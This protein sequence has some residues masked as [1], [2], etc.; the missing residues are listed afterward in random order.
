M[1]AAVALALAP[2]H[3]ALAGTAAAP[4]VQDA[5]G[6]ANALAVQNAK[7]ATSPASVA[8]YDIL[9]VWFSGSGNVNLRLAAAPAPVGL[10][11]VAFNAPGCTVPDSGPSP[12]AAV[13]D[14]HPVSGVGLAL[15]L[16]SSIGQAYYV[17]NVSGN[18]WGVTYVPYSLTGN[19]ITFKIPQSGH[20]VPGAA[21]TRPYAM[22]A[23]ATEA[24]VD[25]TPRGSNAVL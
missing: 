25:I 17:C 12:T 6:D 9:S 21:I 8:A 2:A 14:D 1:A 22:S 5:A 16:K 24:L 18:D 7:L 23:V 4:E 13:L 19:T 11:V 20:L 10:Y 3:S 15:D